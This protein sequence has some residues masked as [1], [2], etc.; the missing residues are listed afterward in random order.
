MDENGAPTQ[1][2]AIF[3]PGAVALSAN[4]KGMCLITVSV[5]LDLADGTRRDLTQSFRVEVK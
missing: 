5:R 3:N 1:L 4:R 2:V